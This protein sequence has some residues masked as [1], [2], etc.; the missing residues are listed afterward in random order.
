MWRRSVL[1]L[2]FIGLAACTTNS[3]P[4]PATHAQQ[5][6]AAEDALTSFLRRY[7]TVPS[8]PDD[9]TTRYCDASIDLNADGVSEIIVYVTGQGWCGSGGCVT[10][11]LAQADSAYRVVT[12]LTITRPPIRVLTESANG[13]RNIGVWVQ[14]GGIQPGYEAELRF[15]GRTY[16]S[17]PSVPPARR[18][19][20]K[21]PGKVVISP[22]QQGKLLYE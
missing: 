4:S 21:A 6:P 13:W 16:P 2:S 12:K 18:L 17:N 8:L 1:T 9:K 15:D 22:S 7:L 14:G 3:A 11:V 20:T 5:T 19:T 10:L